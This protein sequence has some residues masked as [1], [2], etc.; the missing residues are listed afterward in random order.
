VGTE[1]ELKLVTS[2]SGLRK[3]LAL[4]WLRRMAGDRVRRQLLVS[5]YFD[6]RDLALR[7]RGVSLRVR[8]IGRQR[9]QTIKANSDVPMA[10]GEWEAQ[11][12]SDRPNLEL[13]RRTAL[14]PILTDDVAQHL[15][16]VFETRVER[17][18]MPLHVGQSE[19]QL[20]IDEG[21]VVTVDS[22][23]DIAEAEIEL[24]A[25]ISTDWRESSR[26]KFPS[27][28]ASAPRPIGAAP[29]LKGQSTLRGLPKQ[30]PFHR[31]RQWLTP[32]LLSG[33]HASARSPETSSRCDRVIWRGFTSCV[34]GFAVCVRCYLCLRTC[35]K[36][37]NP[38]V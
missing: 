2:K 32:F 27:R 28:W 6:T 1:V 25:A 22:S 5:V 15:K 38:I 16:P 11:I 34:S 13:A 10:R 20:A 30:S 36:T 12:D 33:F 17:T 35:C 26:M 7:E 21:R 3:A 31:P 18:L 4:P 8:R 29:C 24:S 19:V 23:I 37:R 9:V 14:A